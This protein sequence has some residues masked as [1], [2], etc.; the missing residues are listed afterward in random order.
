MELSI[1]VNIAIII[2]LLAFAVLCIYL[3]FTVSKIRDL[4]I[5]LQEDISE[6]NRNAIPLV[7]NLK[8]ISHKVKNISENVD[9]QITILKSSVESIRDMTD[10]I[11]SFEK[12]VQY[13]VEG[14]VMEA[15]SF[16]SALVKAVRAFVAKMKE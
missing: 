7:E 2:G 8:I 3:I 1:F 9:D 16:V 5:K 15:V 12:K 4:V 14:P 6:L 13:E 11:V 10:N